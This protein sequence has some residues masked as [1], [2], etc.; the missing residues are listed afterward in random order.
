MAPAEGA[1]GGPVTDDSPTPS[2]PR[3]LEFA[4]RDGLDNLTEFT[5]MLAGHSRAGQFNIL[6]VGHEIAPRGAT[7]VSR[8]NVVLLRN[9]RHLK[10]S[11]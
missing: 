9:Q 6:T 11:A 3:A 1:E 4:L 10:Q 8:D 5:L 2:D 7:A